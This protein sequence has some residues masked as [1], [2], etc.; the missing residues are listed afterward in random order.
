MQTVAKH[1]FPFVLLF[2]DLSWTVYYEYLNTPEQTPAIFYEMNVV[3]SIF[4]T[5]SLAE[6]ARAAALASCGSRCRLRRM[7]SPAI[8]T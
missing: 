1:R 7:A 6:A 5:L 8:V 3:E 4:A 2:A